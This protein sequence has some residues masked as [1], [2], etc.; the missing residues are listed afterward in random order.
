MKKEVKNIEAAEAIQEDA[1]EGTEFKSVTVP[2]Y[3]CETDVLYD[4]CNLAWDNY[5]LIQPLFFEKSTLFT[6]V[7][8]TD[9][10]AAVAS[11]RAFPDNTTRTLIAK[12]AYDEMVRIN[13]LLTTEWEV[14]AFYIRLAYP[15]TADAE[16][17]SAGY[18]QYKQAIKKQWGNTES[19]AIKAKAYMTDHA[20]DLSGAGTMPAGFPAAF[21]A[22]GDEFILQRKTRNNA[23]GTSVT[24]TA[25]KIAANNEVYDQV[26]WMM[27]MGKIINKFDKT[28]Y[29]KF[30]FDRLKNIVRGRK[31]SGAKGMVKA[32]GAFMPIANVTLSARNLNPKAPQQ[33]YSTMSDANG[34]FFLEMASGEY[35]ITVEAPNYGTVVVPKFRVRVGKKR[36]L[37]PL[38]A[39]ANVASGLLAEAVQAMS[40]PVTKKQLQAAEN[41]VG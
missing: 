37:N 36:R 10:R 25:D 26:I 31:P 19:M 27:D 41:G 38:L 35:E 21:N 16:L 9:A 33:S 29:N 34:D 17:A 7:L 4:V 3:H 15:S 32:D 20:A 2:K 12:N 8:S 5:D 23:L 30:V 13:P 28:E 40:A 39:P 24:G 18:P 14:L 6:A 22:L 11:A 1:A